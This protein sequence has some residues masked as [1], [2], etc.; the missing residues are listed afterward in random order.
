MPVFL[1]PRK[2]ALP[3]T[4]KTSSAEPM[5]KQIVSTN[6]PPPSELDLMQRFKPTFEG[7]RC[8]HFLALGR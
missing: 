3:P 2:S 8:R 1:S 6:P 4:F 5:K 7:C